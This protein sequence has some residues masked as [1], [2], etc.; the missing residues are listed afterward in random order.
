MTPARIIN[1]HYVLQTPNAGQYK[2]LFPDLKVA[3]VQGQTFVAVPQTLEAAR[4]LNNLGVKV[5]PPIL[6]TYDWPGRYT[7]RWYQRETSAFFTLYTR[8][9]CL[10]EMRTGKTL[11]ALWAADYLRREGKI[12][13]TLIVAPLSTLWDV[14]EQNIFESFPLRTFAVLHGPKQKRLDLLRHPADFYIVN[15]HGVGLIEEALSKRPDIDLVIVDELAELRSAKNKRTKMKKGGVLWAPL[16][17]VLNKQ[18]IARAAWGLT[19][20]PTPNA[21][22]DAFGQCKLITPE[23][24]HGHFT[25]FKQ[26][27]MLQF[28]PFKWVPKKGAEQSVARLLKPAIRFKRSVCS[29]MEPCYIDR[30]AQLSEEQTKAYKQ[31]ISQAATELRGQTVTAVNAAVLLSKLIQ[32]ACL[33]SNTEVLCK[34]GWTPI[35]QVTPADSV[36]D[37]VEWV[38]SGGCVY[39]GEKEV[40]SV[41][42]IDMTPDHKILT[43]TG[44]VQ[45][46]EMYGKTS[47]EL[48]WA[49]VRLPRGYS[50][51]GN[52][53]ERRCYVALPMPM[54]KRDSTRRKSS[55]RWQKNSPE[56]LWMS[57]RRYSRKA[58]TELHPSLQTVGCYSSSVLKRKQSSVQVLRRTRHYGVP[59]VGHVI[60]ELHRRHGCVVQ[61]GADIRQGGQQRSVLSRKLSVGFQKSSA[62]QYSVEQADRYL[63]GAHDSRR[64]ERS[65]RH[66]RRYAPLKAAA[67]VAG[68]RGTH[69]SSAEGSAVRP[70]NR[71]PERKNDSASSCRSI[72]AT[73]KDGR[74]T[75]GQRNTGGSSPDHR[76]ATRSKVSV[77]DLI[78]CGPRQRFVV[79]GND[80]VPRIVHN[81]GVAYDATGSLVKF[82]F[83]PRLKILEEMIEEN[84][85]KVLVFV[86]FTG[87]LDTL[88]TELR[89]RWSVAIVDGGVSGSK[90]TEIFR[91]FR[92]LP[93]PW[94]I[95]ANPDTMAHGLDLTTASLSIW[96]APYLKAAKVQQANA[97]TDGSKQTAKIDIAHIYATAE[98]K[99]AYAV[100]REKGRLQ[101][102]FLNLNDR[103]M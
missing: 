65:V 47:E 91:A 34:Q 102:V 60:R 70:V 103:G 32:I 80:K 11:S 4:V 57:L 19:G 44:W 89:K 43:T 18:G 68:R 59:E 93:D 27:T 20:T 30:R 24:Y 67:R 12:H 7:P 45:A 40:I 2:A 66:R 73:S 61:A 22:T 81:C 31:M 8:C 5:E 71:Y 74:G 86:P 76:S 25:A 48:T 88:A 99:R 87:A 38:S 77:Y 49:D 58:S 33:S 35:V 63:Q 50:E 26:E 54:W 28:G 56:E 10:S 15:H 75:L 46:G 97:R 52:G 95:L 14:W 51:R 98:E 41:G 53:G 42:S 23:N 72:W 21:P 6:N 92:T 78:N 39:R 13:R 1:D 69:T 83:G 16:N 101:D 82:D 37:G 62:E 55:P 84:N 29:T 85:E 36:W 17:E 9:Y 90:R 96:Y 100:L 79:R 3:T 64:S 94:I